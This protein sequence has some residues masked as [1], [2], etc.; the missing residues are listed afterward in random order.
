ADTGLLASLGG[1]DEGSLRHD[2]LG[3][4]PVLESFV[5]SE[6]WKQI[7]WS[8]TKPSLHHFRTHGG[9]EVDLVLEDARGRVVGIEVKSSSTVI[10]SDVSGLRVLAEAA[11]KH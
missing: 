10:A 3:F 1:L 8:E 11:G 4:G 7:G 2:R 9:Q 5:A 6:L